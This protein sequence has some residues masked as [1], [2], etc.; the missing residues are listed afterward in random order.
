MKKADKNVELAAVGLRIPAELKTKLQACADTNC[1]TLSD[2]LRYMIER[3]VKATSKRA[4]G[5][6]T[7]PIKKPAN[8]ASLLSVH[9]LGTRVE[10][11]EYK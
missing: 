8:K 7:K 11:N 6:T 9:S 5:W 10:A 2:H 4:H 3:E 1:R